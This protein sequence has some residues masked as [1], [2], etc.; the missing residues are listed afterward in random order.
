ME[1]TKKHIN[2][3]IAFLLICTILITMLS[4]FVRFSLANKQVYLNLLESTN[5]YSVVTEALYK[6][7]N[8][9][10]GNDIK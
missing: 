9:I 7:M 4:A 3:V 6:K 8:A 10:L 5:S 2:I 1:K